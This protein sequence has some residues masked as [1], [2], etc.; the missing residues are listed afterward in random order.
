MRNSPELALEKPLIKSLSLF[1]SKKKNM[2]HFLRESITTQDSSDISRSA[3]LVL[4]L[5]TI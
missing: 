4:Y 3:N 5:F 1:W 2:S